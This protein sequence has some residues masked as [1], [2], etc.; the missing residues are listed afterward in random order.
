MSILAFHPPHLAHHFPQG[1][2]AIEHPADTFPDRAQIVAALP[3]TDQGEVQL[4]YDAL[5]IGGGHGDVDDQGA[6]TQFNGCRNVAVFQRFIADLVDI[7]IRTPALIVD[8]CFS[9]ASL[10]QLAP[11]LTEDGV[12]AGWSC[13]CATTRNELLASHRL[14]A[15]VEQTETALAE[16]TTAASSQ[17]VYLAPDRVLIRHARLTASAG[18]MEANDLPDAEATLARVGSL[19]WQHRPLIA[20]DQPIEGHDAFID[21]LRQL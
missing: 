15:L 18:G 3:R 17:V 4:H 11:L 16:V 20:T 1:V 14:P 21:R 19:T 7:G 2:H 6:P 12:F 13:I 10:P 5:W 8:T 9:L